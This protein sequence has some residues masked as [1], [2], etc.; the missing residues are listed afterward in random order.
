M[1]KKILLLVIFAIAMVGCTAEDI[2]IWKDS[3][4]KDNQQKNEYILKA[5]AS[6]TGERLSAFFSFG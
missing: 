5:G 6:H 3:T 4:D 2:A 1:F